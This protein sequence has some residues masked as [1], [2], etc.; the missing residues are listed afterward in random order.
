MQ[1]IGDLEDAW[2]SAKIGELHFS[3]MYKAQDHWLLGVGDMSVQSGVNFGTHHGEGHR[4]GRA[5]DIRPMRTDGES[6]GVVQGKDGYSEKMTRALARTIW[7]VGLTHFE[8]Q[9]ELVY[10]NDGNLISEGLATPMRGHD[11]HLHVQLHSLGASDSG[12]ACQ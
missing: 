2:F 4:E 7:Q 1:F 3:E 5:V 11:N 6:K 9:L 12:G 10:F 8:Y